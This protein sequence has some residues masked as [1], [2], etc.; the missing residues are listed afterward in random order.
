MHRLAVGP[1]LNVREHTDATHFEDI[2]PVAGHGLHSGLPGAAPVGEAVLLAW[3]QHDGHESL[4]FSSRCKRES[5]LPAH[6]VAVELVAHIVHG[7]SNA[8]QR[9]NGVGHGRFYRV[10]CVVCTEVEFVVHLNVHAILIMLLAAA[11]PPT[12]MAC[13]KEIRYNP[14]RVMIHFCGN[15]A[16]EAL[17]GAMCLTVFAVYTLTSTPATVVRQT[18]L[19]DKLPVVLLPATLAPVVGPAPASFGPE[20]PSKSL[21]ARKAQPPLSATE[22][23]LFVEWDAD[24]ACVSEECCMG[25]WHGWR[26][27]HDLVRDV[28]VRFVDVV[29]GSAR[30]RMAVYATGDIVS[31]EIAG[32][33]GWER[34][35]TE[36]FIRTAA[37]NNEM[38]VLDVG[39]NIGWYSF[40]LAANGFRVFAFE[41]FRQN[42]NLMRLTACANPATAARIRLFAGGLGDRDQDCV[43]ISETGVNIGDGHTVCRAPGEPEHDIPAGYAVIG[44][45]TVRRLDDV[46]P[47]DAG[48]ISVMKMDTEG[49]EVFA[50]RGAERLFQSPRRPQLLLTE[51]NP[52]LLARRDAQ[53][54]EMLNFIKVHGYACPDVRMPGDE[55]Y[56]A[57]VRHTAQSDGG[58]NMRCTR[59]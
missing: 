28:D 57:F 25:R 17:V 29:A 53:P 48:P 52:K 27:A 21:P 16:A 35:D 42:V 47:A 36:E 15:R 54:S 5:C 31:G 37:G 58:I 13:R 45:V 46:L 51:F 12:R 6:R 50:L 19:A 44:G 24:P 59:T 56:D 18:T 2:V 9:H 20:A 33:K 39:A 41:P 23:D 14:R 40:A 4:I 3:R 22:P 10:G 8:K 1:P 34:E 11:A 30:F 38:A 43:L 7:A 55:G 26:H 49:F 32:S